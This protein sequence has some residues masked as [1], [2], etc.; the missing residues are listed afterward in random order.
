MIAV[1]V[2]VLNVAEGVAL[3]VWRHHAGITAAVLTALL[4]VVPTER[5]PRL[6][7]RHT[8]RHVHRTITKEATS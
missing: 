3:V 8:G 4:A 7:R 1:W 2:T 5:G 6:L